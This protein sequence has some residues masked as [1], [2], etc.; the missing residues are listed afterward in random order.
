M[1][2]FAPAKPSGFKELGF[3]KTI[4]GLASEIRALY[5]A[6]EIP[7]V[8]GYSGGKDSTAT[9]QLIWNAVAALP[10]EKRTKTIHVISTDTLVENPV[11]SGWVAASLE[12]MGRS[13]QEQRLPFSPN[14]LLPELKDRFWVNMIGRGYPAPRPKF[15][16]CTERLKINP[17]NNFILRVV[18]E[19]GEV[20]LALGTRKAE[21]QARAASMEHYSTGAREGLQ[22]HGQLD[23]S[24]VYAP[25]AT[26]S[27][28][29]VWQYLMQ[30]RNPWGID[31]KDLLGMYQGATEDGECPLVVD[32]SSQSC[33]DSR[34]GCYV[35][36]M[37][38]EDKSMRSMIANDSEKEW[39][40]PLLQF[41]NKYLGNL[42][43]RPV[44]DFR[45]MNGSLFVHHDRLVHGPYTQDY[46][47]V[48]LKALLEAQEAVNR[49]LPSGL[50]TLELITMDELQEIRRIWLEDKR[51]IED[52]LP[53]I[54][55]S[56]CGKDFPSNSTPMAVLRPDEIDTL[57]GVSQS[58]GVDSNLH[59][60][61]VRDLITTHSRARG[62]QARARLLE[63][64]DEVLDRNAF[65]DADEALQIALGRRRSASTEDLT[66]SIE[67]PLG[68]LFVNITLQEQHDIP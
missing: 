13:A 9:L 65:A 33:G 10:A 53:A 46:R 8:V 51:E 67:R 5:L 40:L 27:N 44:R 2:T 62:A 38:T 42:E 30:V 48:M 36:T 64:L 3:R 31:N 57:R 58:A 54:Y 15:R 23:R 60:Q 41:R 11:I 4:D 68:P 25:I 47:A 19:S 14:R 26:W 18:Q 56:V 17:S 7:W 21:S 28:D 59:Y 66:E 52:H 22:R 12:T 35:C 29:D 1:S 43:D 24:W 61:L 63:E 20:I 49:K 39:M 45:R 34:F 6:D 16:W 37:V 50:N 55:R 32:T